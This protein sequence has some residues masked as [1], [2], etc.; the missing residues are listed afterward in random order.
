M[1]RTRRPVLFALLGLL[2]CVGAGY[3]IHNHMQPHS[4]A[5]I[6][7]KYT[8][9]IKQ[10][11]TSSAHYAQNKFFDPNGS[12]GTDNTAYVASLTDY[13]NSQLSYTFTGSTAT[14]LTYSYKADAVLRSTFSGK[15][16]TAKAADVWAKTYSLLKPVTGSQKT[17]TLTLN[18]SVKIPFAEYAATASQ[19]RS[20]YNIPVSNEV[21]VT[22]TVTV[23][24]KVN[25]VP[26]TN[27]QMSTI[28]APLDEL[29][30]KIAVQF[31]KT[32]F[33]EVA[34][35]RAWQLESIIT[36]Y[37]FPV[38]IVLAL[39]GVSLVVYGFRK[40]IIKSPYQRELA[41][42]YRYNGD[43]I[44]K[45]RRPVSLARK[46]IVDLDSFDDLLSVE[47]ETGAPIVAN[48]LGDTATRFIIA[49]EGTAYVFTLGDPTAS[50]GVHNRPP[51]PPQRPTPPAPRPEPKPQPK[52]AAKSAPKL[53][54]KTASI[55]DDKLLAERVDRMMKI[56]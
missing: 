37:E 7:Q 5:P 44:V 20:T 41:Q 53:P 33:Q 56:Q 40:Q 45:A 1:Q 49:S 54:A 4:A 24:G 48:E 25:G 35:K 10:S 28:T 32:D 42:I 36:T 16:S 55:D 43:I 15:D 29:V 14:T 23:S 6:A 52:P 46:T 38:A 26:F 50:Q 34:S 17:K 2:M 27:T 21:V 19:F 47:E 12:P 3:L 51:E 18:P 39:S 9:Q 11:A 30:Y 13:L 22:Y 8:Y 31:N